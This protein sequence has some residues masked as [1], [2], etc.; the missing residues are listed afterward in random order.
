[1]AGSAMV[2]TEKRGGGIE[3]IKAAWTSDSVNGN[4]SGT[5][6]NFYSG[7]FIG[8]ISVPGGTTPSD[9]Y[10]VTVTDQDSVDLTLAGATGNQ[11]AA[12]TTYTASA[13][14]AGCA[15]SR[16]TFNV[17]S[18]GNSKNGTVYLLIQ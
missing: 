17:S 15:V 16:L 10:T 12:S 18:A 9:N 14:M 8:L 2:F 13:S 11:K 6:T 7:K 3:K 1:M 4:V 5:T